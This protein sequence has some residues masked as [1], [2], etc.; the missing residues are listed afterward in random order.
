MLKG[1]LNKLYIEIK[2]DIKI[3]KKRRNKM[4][5]KIRAIKKE[6]EINLEL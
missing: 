3:G 1:R 4:L 6:I 2:R 5:V